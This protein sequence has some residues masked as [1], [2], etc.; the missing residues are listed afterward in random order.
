MSFSFYKFREILESSKEYADFLQDLYKFLEREKIYGYEQD[1]LSILKG[2][3]SLEVMS[4]LKKSFYRYDGIKPKDLDIQMMDRKMMLDRF[5]NYKGIKGYS[6]SIL[7]LWGQHHKEGKNKIIEIKGK[8]LYHLKPSKD[9]LRIW[10][11]NTPNL[12]G[13]PTLKTVKSL[14]GVKNFFQVNPGDY[15]ISEK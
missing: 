5:L 3:P 4:D 1:I 2:E 12:S 6:E 14:Y 8:E 15:M 10:T 9:T 13:V 11:W 7:D